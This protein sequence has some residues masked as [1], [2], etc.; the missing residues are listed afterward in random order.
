M[1]NNKKVFL[2][3]KTS[4]EAFIEI[5][6]TPENIPKL[7]TIFTK[8]SLNTGTFKTEPYERNPSKGSV[9]YQLTKLWR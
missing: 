7:L 8:E 9:R 6:W 1:K 4:Y 2:S 3:D 5:K